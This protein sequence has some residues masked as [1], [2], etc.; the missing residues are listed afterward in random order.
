MLSA[1][2]YG[3]SGTALLAGVVT[4]CC[5]QPV[6]YTPGSGLSLGYRVSHLDVG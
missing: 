1:L 2:M 3:A 6:S 4:S 5:Y